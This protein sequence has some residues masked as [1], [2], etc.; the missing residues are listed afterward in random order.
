[1]ERV[2]DKLLINNQLEQ[3]NKVFLDHLEENMIEDFFVCPLN[4]INIFGYLS[5]FIK[6]RHIVNTFLKKHNSAI[7]EVCTMG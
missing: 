4:L 6:M 1:L 7:K 3:Y 5:M 2:T